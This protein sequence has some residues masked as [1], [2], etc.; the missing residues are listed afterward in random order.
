MTVKTPYRIFCAAFAWI[1][2]ALQYYVVL[3]S[4]EHV[5]FAAASL[6]FFGFFT[7][8]TNIIVGLAFTAPL[9]KQSNTVH[10][11]FE[12]PTVRAAIAL[13][14][15]FVAIIYHVLL[16]GDHS[17]S[18]LGHFT[19]IGLHTLI[20]ILYVIDWLVF[21]RKHPLLYANIPYWVIYPLIYGLFNIV[22]GLL[23]GFYP[24]PFVDVSQ[25]G[26]GGVAINMLGFTVLYA[27]GAALFIAIGNQL[28]KVS[29]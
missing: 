27:A 26:A 12:R 21:A 25:L 19:N 1:T 11:F 16:A 10:L 29:P 28:L 6:Y 20:P 17:P 8:L 23:T 7:I 13:Y 5:N 9:F 24:Y 2:L 4:G 14:I 18:G 3:I 15:S 22:R